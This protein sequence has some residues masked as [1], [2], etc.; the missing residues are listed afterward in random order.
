MVSVKRLQSNAFDIVNKVGLTL[1]DVEVAT[2][3]D[4]SPVL[5]VAG[6]FMAGLATH[7]SAEPNTLVIRADPEERELFIEDAPD[8]YYLTDYY[9]RYPLVLVR[10]QRVTREA[11]RELLS[12]SHRLTL[13]KT[14]L[15]RRRQA[16]T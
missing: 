5:K 6:V 1:P 16:A 15:R 12:S 4:G 2:R 3:Y 7:S 10:L 11:L 14:R 9:R 13:P 8:T